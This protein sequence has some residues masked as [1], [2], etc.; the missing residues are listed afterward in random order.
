MRPPPGPEWLLL[1]VSFMRWR[2]WARG[3]VAHRSEGEAARGQHGRLP[4]AYL[5]GSRD[6]ALG[7]I[8][9]R[10]R[11]ADCVR[12]GRARRVR[13][14][15]VADARR[16]RAGRQADLR[17]GHRRDHDHGRAKEDDGDV[18]RLSGQWEN[19]PLQGRRR[20][21]VPYALRHR[22]PGCPRD[23]ERADST[24]RSPGRDCHMRRF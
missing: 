3:P 13:E 16:G 21:T 6:G 14:D 18:Q 10:D 4:S 17:P 2:I 11:G 24:R 19:H 7:G 1:A 9:H 5:A 22:S 20:R 8:R 23:G 12:N 15:V